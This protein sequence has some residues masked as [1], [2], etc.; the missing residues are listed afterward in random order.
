MGEA[1][2]LLSPD[3]QNTIFTWIEEGPDVTDI[4]NPE[5]AQ[6]YVRSWRMRR[7]FWLNGHLSEPWI[8]RCR[9]LVE[10]FGEPTESAKFSAF[11]QE[12]IG[13]R[14]PISAEELK[15]LPVKNIVQRL[16]S[17]EP[18]PG[19]MMPSREGLAERLATAVT[20][21]PRRFVAD[22]DSFRGVH[23]TYVRFLIQAL[24]NVLATGQV[25][26][27]RILP[28]LKW[29]VDQGEEFKGKAVKDRLD[30]DPD[31]RGAR[32]T[33]AYLLEGG[34]TQTAVYT[35][36]ELRAAAWEILAVLLRD[37]DPTPEDEARQIRTH[38]DASHMSIN[39][40]RGIAMHTVVRYALWVEKHLDE[41]DPI[42][43]RK[44]PEVQ[45]AFENG[46]D[47][48]LEP[49]L[50]VRSVY[51]RWFAWIQHLD[52]KW[53]R[54][55]VAQIFPKD[56]A[57]LAMWTVA[58]G[59]YVCFSAAFSDS[60]QTLIP[61]YRLAIE[62]LGGVLPSE[63]K[64][65]NIEARLAEHLMGFFWH[66]NL[67]LDGSD[68][69]IGLFWKKAPVELRRKALQ[70]LCRW[71]HTKEAIGLEILKRLRGLWEWRVQTVS[72]MQSDPKEL[73]SFSWWFSSGQFDDEWAIDQLEQLQKT[74]NGNRSEFRFH[75][76]AG[77]NGSCY[78]SA[79]GA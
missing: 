24:Q 51:G 48:K 74:E 41:P 43:L 64:S 46:L 63:T 8:D 70:A 4:E 6:R 54:E 79:R 72:E 56:D 47:E 67:E 11:A 68:G 10:E 13:S 18:S 3:Q 33:L 36:F 27:I 69:L 16:K 50:T 31:W 40:T 19:F 42:T 21:D 35:P 77:A 44:M 39:R 61:E 65:Q 55:H 23:P 58:W 75:A 59:S 66:G 30:E 34:F 25:D 76:T 37:S 28:F 9:K 52:S 2:N 22:I 57:N 38:E 73:S 5:E 53:A 17:W 20:E 62:R 49:S 78:A 12:F 45:A 15:A 14:S 60:L 32:R 7:L 71:L 26:W 1:F 29:I